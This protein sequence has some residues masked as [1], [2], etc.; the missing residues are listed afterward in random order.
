M[1]C[2]YQSGLLHDIW[3]KRG[4]STKYTTVVS[5]WILHHSHILLRILNTSCHM[6]PYWLCGV[7]CYIQRLWCMNWNRFS[8]RMYM[9]MCM[10]VENVG[11]IMNQLVLGTS[12]DH[13]CSGHLKERWD[14]RI[15]AEAC[16]K[17]H[18]AKP[19]IFVTWPSITIVFLFLDEKVKVSRIIV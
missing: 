19:V 2:M 18:L 5:T 7:K 1:W 6:V 11:G 13:N 17:G 4:F 3:S 14:G 16:Y 12:N 15:L 9:P 8:A 10:T